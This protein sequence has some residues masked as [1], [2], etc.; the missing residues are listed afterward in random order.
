MNTLHRTLL[1]IALGT[2]PV[3]SAGVSSAASRG[4]AIVAIDDCHGRFLHLPDGRAARDACPPPGATARPA[5]GDAGRA[6]D[7]EITSPDDPPRHRPTPR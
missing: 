6:R 5:R 2:V 7:G 1:A 3:L 4:A